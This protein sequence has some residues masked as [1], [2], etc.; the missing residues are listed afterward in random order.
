MKYFILYVLIA[1]TAVGCSS[2]REPVGAEESKVA[3]N[4]ITVGAVMN[5]KLPLT[6]AEIQPSLHHVVL[7]GKVDFNPNEVT[8]VFS[9]ASG[10]VSRINV[11]QG[12]P[13]VK[14]QIL[15]E[16]Q[17]SDIAN[18]ISDFRKSSAQLKNAERALT[19]VKELVAAKVASQRD[20]QQAE[21]DEAQARAD[22]DRSLKTLKIFGADENTTS[23]TYEIRAPIDGVVMERFAQPGSQ[24][25]ND[26]SQA[27]FTIGR[28][29]SLWISLDVYPDQLH[30]IAQG[31]SAIV[32][33]SGFED[34]PFRTFIQYISPVVDPNS[35]TTKV[36][37]VV[38]NSGGVLKPAMFVSAN[39]SHPS[40]EGLYIPSTAAFYDGDGKV[41]VFLKHGDRSYE[42]R[43]I[44]EGIIEPTRIEVVAGL[45]P[46]D[47]LVADKAL[48]LNDEMHT[49]QQ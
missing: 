22:Y 13:V 11:T 1:V 31:D 33:A 37:C 48:F 46:G 35:F 12:D 27:A 41:Y 14:G 24:V 15:A 26:G 21:S 2:N 39:V 40:G 10:L 45:A 32:L 43:A 47:S 16:V 7:T 34:H 5:A 9:L 49:A 17:S 36:R 44:E 25:R 18:A 42:K 23:A 6:T 19:R 8:H 3:K 38:P 4:I 30:S 29:N 20:L 28:T